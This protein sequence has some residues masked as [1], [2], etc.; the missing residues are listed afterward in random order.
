M[1]Q[2]VF[3]NFGIARPVHQHFQQRPFIRGNQRVQQI[4][5]L[6]ASL[7]GEMP[8][9]AEINQANAIAGQENNVAGVRVGMEIAMNQHHPEYRVRPARG[10]FDGV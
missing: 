5:D 3:I 1:R 9:H 2:P 6:V 7:L 10:E 4:D 8:H